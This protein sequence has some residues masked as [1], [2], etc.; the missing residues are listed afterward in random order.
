MELYRIEAKPTPYGWILTS[1]AF[2]IAVD[3][4]PKD[5]DNAVHALRTQ[6]AEEAQKRLGQGDFLPADDALDTPDDGS[7]IFY[8]ETD[9]G[10]RFIAHSS[11]TVRR[12]ISMP[13]WMDMRLRR[14]NIDASRLFQEAAAA[15]LKELE[16]VG[17]NTPNITSVQELKDRCPERVLD[18]YFKSRMEQILDGSKK[19]KTH[20]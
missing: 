1:P 20:D 5:L 6:I 12:N 2:G 16:Q 15:K 19:E 8:M 10:N 3:A 4:C 14:N 11:E 17:T 7:V 18:M 9:F 13:A